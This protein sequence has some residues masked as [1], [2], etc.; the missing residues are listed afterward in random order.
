MLTSSS[1]AQIRRILALNTSAKARRREACFV[2]EGKK[3]VQEMPRELLEK[4]Y[5]SSDRVD[6]YAEI[7]QRMPEVETITPELFAKI[8]DTLTPQGILAVV[9]QPAYERE[10]LLKGA[11]PLLLMMEDVQDPGNVGTM[12]RTAEGAGVTGVLMS[13]GCA[14]IFQPKTVRSTMGSIYRMPFRRVKDFSSEV[15]Y[16]KE[17]GVRI[18]ATL[19]GARQDYTAASYREPTGFL[20][21]NEGKGLSKEMATLADVKIRI[22]MEGKVES[23]NAS[24]S[25]ALCLY[26][27]HRQRSAEECNATK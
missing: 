19:L 4:V 12:I 3:L 2:A 24:I 10:E 15:L 16:Y 20:I 1:N 25:A 6:E 23:L 22:P 14:D 17:Q 18:Y 26:E 11:Q 9:R 7:L 8:S 27:A 5:I 13:T 21:G